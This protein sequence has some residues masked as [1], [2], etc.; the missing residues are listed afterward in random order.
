MVLLNLLT[1]TTL[2]QNE[3]VT[4]I[5]TKAND[6]I[7]SYRSLLSDEQL[8]EKPAEEEQTEEELAKILE[9]RKIDTKIEEL[10]IDFKERRKA[11]RKKKEEE[12]ESK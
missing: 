2:L 11:Y 7:R 4:A 9:D 6:A 8:V 3:D 10:I 5:N 1:L 12:D